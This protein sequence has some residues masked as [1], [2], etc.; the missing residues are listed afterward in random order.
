MGKLT[1]FAKGLLTNRF[2][3]VLA[4]LN[5]CYFAAKGFG[6]IIVHPLSNFDKIL[7]IQNLPAAA[8]SFISLTVIKFLFTASDRFWSYRF[9]F[10]IT[11]FFVALQWLFIGWLAKT[12]ARKLCK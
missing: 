6:N 11:L 5:V 12:V 10:L 7:I 8:F 1:N 3:I 4:T 2:G 9:M